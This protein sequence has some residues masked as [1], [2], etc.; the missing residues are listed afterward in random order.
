MVELL[1]F[2][3][4]DIGMTLAVILLTIFDFFIVGV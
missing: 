4:L 3:K 1:T 2:V